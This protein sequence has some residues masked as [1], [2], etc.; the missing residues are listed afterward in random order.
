[1]D[2]QIGTL[3]CQL[4]ELLILSQVLFAMCAVIGLLSEL[5]WAELAVVGRFA[6]VDVHMFS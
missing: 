2:L 4:G 1:M 3:F 5:G 6:C